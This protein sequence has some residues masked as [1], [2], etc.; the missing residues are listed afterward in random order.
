MNGINGRAAKTLGGV[1]LG[2][3]LAATAGCTSLQ[4]SGAQQTIATVTPSTVTETVVATTTTQP[5]NN[6][7]GPG[8]SGGSGGTTTTKPPTKTTTRPHTTTTTTH[9]GAA[10]VSLEVVQKPACPI[11]GTPDAPFSKPGVPVIIK[12]KVTGAD[13]AA[14][15]VDNP[16]TYGA[17]G[18]DY[19]A[20]GQLELSFPC[21]GTTGSTTHKYTVWPK[22]FKTVSR[23][24]SVSAT[25]HA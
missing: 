18:S 10:V 22:G 12:W 2:L 4:S 17:Y 14:I 23:T 3:L 7:S 21:S 16:G 9:A 11:N 20:S 15:A 6:G 24:I 13:G 8:G 25:N 5:G 1:T 19:A